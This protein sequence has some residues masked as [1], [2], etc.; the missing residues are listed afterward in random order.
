VL[1]L[2]IASL[3]D[4]LNR[5]AHVPVAGPILATAGT[6]AAADNLLEGLA[7]VP[8]MQVVRVGQPASIRD[9]LRH[10]SLAALAEATPEGQKVQQFLFH[11]SDALLADPSHLAACARSYCPF[12]RVAHDLAGPRSQC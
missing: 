7:E 8:G 5:T 4:L 6:N 9:G 1:R 10:L 2:L 11:L 3:H 12:R